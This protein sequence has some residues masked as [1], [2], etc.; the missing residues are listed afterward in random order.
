MRL[1]IIF[2]FVIGLKQTVFSQIVGT[3]YMTLVTPNPIINSFSASSPTI[4]AGSSTT[5][6]P[7]F[8]Q[9]SASINN[10][11]GSVSTGQGYSVSPSV[12]TTYTL[13][14]TNSIGKS[15]YNP[16]QFMLIRSLLPLNL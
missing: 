4:V 1:L 14:V 10:A 3:P 6:N 13:T 11:V 8:D 5:L 2:L 15:T 9:G 16:L 12:T 7:S